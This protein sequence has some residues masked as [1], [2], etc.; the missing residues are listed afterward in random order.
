[1]ADPILKNK[2][3][4][5]ETIAVLGHIHP[6]GDCVGSALALKSYVTDC[7]PATTTARTPGSRTQM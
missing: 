2:I 4:R 5:A 7:W 6:D 1:M 3:E